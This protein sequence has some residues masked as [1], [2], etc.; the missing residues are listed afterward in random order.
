MTA[1]YLYL[2]MERDF[3]KSGE[4]VVKGG[5]TFSTFKRA[6][7]YP[8]GSFIIASA[9]C[10]DMVADEAELLAVLGR[11]F[12]K[13]PDIGREYFE[14]PINQIEACFHAFNIMKKQ[15]APTFNAAPYLT[16][17]QQPQ[18]PQ[19]SP[20]VEVDMFDRFLLYAAEKHWFV[21]ISRENFFKLVKVMMDPSSPCHADDSEVSS[22]WLVADPEVPGRRTVFPTYQEIRDKW[23][24]TDTDDDTMDRDRRGVAEGISRRRFDRYR[25]MAFI[26]KA[27]A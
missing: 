26:S 12:K 3:A 17:H 9:T 10:A 8:K 16:A 5:R 27:V 24:A 4:S 20:V 2:L 14:G 6:S 15:G 23:A 11:T 25:A 13:R 1:G 22:Y 7:Q 18:Q 19:D 21:T